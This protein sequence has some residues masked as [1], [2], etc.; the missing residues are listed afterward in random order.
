MDAIRFLRAVEFK[1]KL[2]KL[3]LGLLFFVNFILVFLTGA[4][5]LVSWLLRC[6]LLLC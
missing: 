6:C 2:F 4:V 5:F 1:L 3:I